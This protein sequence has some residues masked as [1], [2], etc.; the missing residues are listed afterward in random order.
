MHLKSWM[1][2]VAKSD[3]A[4]FDQYDYCQMY[5]VKKWEDDDEKE[6]LATDAYESFIYH[7][8]NELVIIKYR[9]DINDRHN[10]KVW[11]LKREGNLHFDADI[12]VRGYYS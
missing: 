4:L 11:N 10:N 12:F 2:L 9:K 8:P 1:P 6:V 7:E 5:T 3:V